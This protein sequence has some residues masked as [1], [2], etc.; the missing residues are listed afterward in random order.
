MVDVKAHDYVDLSPIE[1]PPG[2]P[3]VPVVARMG[4]LVDA[5][6]G[7]VLGAYDHTILGS[8]CRF[9][10]DQTVRTVVS[11]ILRARAAGPHPNQPRKDAR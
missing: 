11:L 6:D 1:R 7:V 4:A 9:S 8:I 5:L 3:Y 10:D 2:G